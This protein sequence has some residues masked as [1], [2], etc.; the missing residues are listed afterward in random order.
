MSAPGPPCG[1]QHT[2]RSPG[3]GEEGSAED[4]VRKPYLWVTTETEIQTEKDP[5][6]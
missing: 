4:W 5:N 6:P 1:A 3:G 2:R